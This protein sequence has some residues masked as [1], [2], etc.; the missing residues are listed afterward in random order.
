MMGLGL[1]WALYVDYLYVYRYEMFKCIDIVANH[2]MLLPITA[3]PRK[4]RMKR[5]KCKSYDTLLVWIKCEV[6][7]MM[8]R[9]GPWTPS[10]GGS[11]AGIGKGG[12]SVCV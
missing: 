6:G 1:G 4:M 3:C 8:A 7:E 5:F 10:G 11:F 12:G 9:L 2:L